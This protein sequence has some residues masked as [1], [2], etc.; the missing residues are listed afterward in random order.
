[1]IL[2]VAGVVFSLVTASHAVLYKRDTRAALG[3]LALC[4]FVPWVGGVLYWIFG[5]NRIRTH[6]QELHR[7]GR[8]KYLKDANLDAAKGLDPQATV[9]SSFQSL[10]RLSTTV[11]QRPL[12]P[13]N[14]VRALQDG[15]EA[16]PAMLKAIESAR[17]WLYLSTYIFDSD[18]TGQK[19]VAALSRACSRGVRV[20]VLVDAFGAQYSFPP[21]FGLLRKAGVPFSKFLP[22]SL[23]LNRFHPNLRDHRKMLLADNRVAFTGGMNIGDRH[24]VQKPPLKRRVS[25]LHFELTGPIVQELQDVFLED[26]FFSSGESIPPAAAATPIEGSLDSVLARVVSGGPNEDFE[27]INWILL[28]ALAVARE[29]IQIMTP[30]FVPDRVIIAA[31][32]AAAL[33]GIAIE[34]ILPV[35]NN[36][37]FVGWASRALLWEMLHKGVKF[38]YQPA[39][40]AHTKLMVVDGYYGLIGSSNWDARSL[41][42]NF[43]LDVETYGQAFA[44]D[45]ETYFGAVLVRSREISIEE[46]RKDSVLRRFRNSFFKLFSPYL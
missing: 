34:I 7:Q 5:V 2:S 6:A 3:W 44:R 33:R 43:E 39:P 10:H 26:W 24:L 1:M 4:L 37:P 23:S 11:T 30:Y 15:E 40:F 18:E 9:P 12:L 41:R 14:H 27:K 16:Y 25:D 38:Y 8:W 22:F 36:L 29:K 13:G 32:N 17:E 35:K 46:I 45:L 21:I 42:L 19:F 31:L 20:R 28:G